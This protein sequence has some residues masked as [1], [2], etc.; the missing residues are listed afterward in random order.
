MGESRHQPLRPSWRCAFC[1]DEWPC[2]RR[3]DELTAECG[4]SRVRLAFYMAAFFS[5]ALDD[6]PQVTPRDLYQRFLGWFR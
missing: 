6:H 1:G 5:D 3:R 4:Q 2:R